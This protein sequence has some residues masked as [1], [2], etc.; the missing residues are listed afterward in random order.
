MTNRIVSPEFVSRL[1]R[2][3]SVATDLARALGKLPGGALPGT[4]GERAA[5][6]NLIAAFVTEATAAA[7]SASTNA[8]HLE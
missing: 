2:T 1:I 5:L 4:P 7:G 8:K 3:A 6:R